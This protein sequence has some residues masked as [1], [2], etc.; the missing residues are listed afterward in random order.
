MIAPLRKAHRLGWILIAISLPVGF[1]AGLAARRAPPTGHHDLMASVAAI[2]MSN[3]RSGPAISWNDGRISS[4]ILVDQGVLELTPIE[5]LQRPD[6]LVYLAPFGSANNS[7]IPNDGV[8]L[9]RLSGSATRRMALPRTP[10][11]EHTFGD[12]A[13][14]MLY[15]LAHQQVLGTAML[16][17]TDAPPRTPPA[18]LYDNKDGEP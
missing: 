1:G 16:S 18:S 15:S 14:L 13:V 10:A 9:G 17:L 12:R 6:V 3:A 4:R 7:A 11:G 5:G 8:L 2:D